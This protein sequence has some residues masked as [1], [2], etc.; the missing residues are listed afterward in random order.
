VA[1]EGRYYRTKHVSLLLI[2][3]TLSVLR[4]GRR[5]SASRRLIYLSTKERR[6]VRRTR[7]TK[8][9]RVTH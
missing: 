5:T 4:T 6:T 3:V 1:I 8:K 2:L 7:R 9:D